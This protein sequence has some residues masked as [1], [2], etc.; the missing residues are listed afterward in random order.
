MAFND[1]MNRV[2]STAGRKSVTEEPATNKR[3]A[4]RKSS[5]MPA[6][7]LFPGTR[8]PIPCAIRD[9]SSTGA[10][11]ELTSGKNHPNSDSESMPDEFTLIMRMD[12]MEVDCAVAWRKGNMLGVRYVSPARAL[13]KA[14]PAAR[15]R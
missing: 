5:M 13:P 4:Q 8:Q 2:M 10:K 12:N 11:L 1:R 14:A 15:R 6:G 3:W 7:L 9:S